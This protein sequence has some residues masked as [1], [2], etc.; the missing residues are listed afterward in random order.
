MRNGLVVAEVA[1]ALVLLIGAGLMM[2]SFKNLQRTDI[3]ADPSN[4][5]TFRIGLAGNAIHR[6]RD[7]AT[8]LRAL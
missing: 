4:T 1:L 6:S 7:A 2:R 5:L 3:G 8:L